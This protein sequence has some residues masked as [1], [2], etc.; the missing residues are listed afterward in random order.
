MQP[1]IV[2]DSAC[3]LAIPITAVACITMMAA[4]TIVDIVITVDIVFIAVPGM[5]TVIAAIIAMEVLGA[6]GTAV[7]V[8]VGSVIVV[9]LP[10]A[11]MGGAGA[12]T[13]VDTINHNRET[14]RYR[15]GRTSV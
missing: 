1:Q 2:S 13:D 5:V 12:V 6:I 10:S 8:M 14:A 9:T 3:P 15:A 4:G 7:A 11:I